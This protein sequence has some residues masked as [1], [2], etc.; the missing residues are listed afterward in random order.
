MR[1]L[2]K[3]EAYVAQIKS[4]LEKSEILVLTSIEGV[5]V[6][7]INKLRKELR[8]NQS[9]IRVV[10]NTLFRRAI[11]DLQMDAL[12]DYTTGSTAV[13][14]GYADPIAPVKVLFDFASKVP[15]FKFKAG[16]FN[17]QVLDINKLESLSKLPSK[18]Q[19][20]AMLLS[21]LIAPIRNLISVTQGPIRKIVYALNAIKEKKQLSSSGM[22]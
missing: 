16:Y 22:L 12:E 5:T 19:L 15:K 4:K 3:K 1:K 6:E 13:V 14:F 11:K 7:E 17:K 20:L 10:K 21:T 8:A 2:A 9:E 18:E